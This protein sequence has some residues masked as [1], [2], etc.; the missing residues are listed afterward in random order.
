MRTLL[1]GLRSCH[2]NEDA[3]FRLL[4]ALEL[5]ESKKIR[6]QVLEQER[7]LAF[8][9]L[10]NGNATDNDLLCWSMLAISL[11]KN[12]IAFNIEWEGQKVIRLTQSR[13]YT[14]Q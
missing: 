10:L 14:V 8:T 6:Q 11:Q 3:F 1:R 7:T 2:V 5:L 13:P 12:A 4:K 9:P